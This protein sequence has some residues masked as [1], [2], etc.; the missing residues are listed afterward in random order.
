MHT[1]MLEQALQEADGSI[2][3]EKKKGKAYGSKT[4]F[5]GKATALLLSLE[6]FLLYS[7]DGLRNTL[8]I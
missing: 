2:L 3:K 1:G 8:G 5:A 6:A 7:S 4:I